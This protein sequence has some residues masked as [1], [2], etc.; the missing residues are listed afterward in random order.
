MKKSTLMVS[1]FLVLALLLAS[2]GPADEG[3]FPAEPGFDGGMG[4]PAPGEIPGIGTEPAPGDIPETGVEPTLPDDAD[5]TPML[6]E[7]PVATEA[8]PTPDEDETVPVTPAPAEQETDT[9][10]DTGLRGAQVIPET[11]REAATLLSELLGYQVEDQNGNTLGTVDDFILNM[12]E[13]HIV[14][15]VLEADTSLELEDGN[16]LVFPY[17]TVS[18]QDGI[19]DVDQRVIVVSVDAEQFT[20]SPS[21]RERLDLTT[22]D[23][24]ADIRAHWSEVGRLSNLSTDCNVP[25]QSGMGENNNTED[26]RRQD[27]TRIAY[28]TEV[29]DMQLVDGNGNLMGQ[30]EEVIVEP[31]SG[32]LPYVAIRMDNELVLA[33][34]GALNLDEATRDQNLVLLVEPEILENAPRVDSLPHDGL[35]GEPFEYWNQ[36]VPMTREQLP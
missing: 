20:A 9:N 15:V 14:Y 10:G 35:R 23:W 24:E 11:G 29:L 18:L 27:I 13:A 8:V 16:M 7:T 34:F 4:D 2:C 36:H 1:A 31:E 6:E 30:V 19:I 33:P 3:E 25:V 12:C 5:P 28:A 32:W 17:E 21:V 22:T 26:S